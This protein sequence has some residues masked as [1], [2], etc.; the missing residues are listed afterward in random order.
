[1]EKSYTDTVAEEEKV[2]FIVNYLKPMFDKIK[3]YDLRKSRKLLNKKEYLLKLDINEEVF[4]SKELYRIGQYIKYCTKYSGFKTYL[5]INLS[6]VNR[7]QDKITYL[8]LDMMIFY[9]VNICKTSY[10]NLIYNIKA[11]IF[12][13]SALC[14]STFQRYNIKYPKEFITYK[15]YNELYLK[16]RL[17]EYHDET[18]VFYRYLYT[19]SDYSKLLISTIASEVQSTLQPYFEKSWINNVCKIIEEIIDNAIS[20]NNSMFILDLHYSTNLSSNKEKDDYEYKGI[21][22]GIINIGEQNLYTKLME[23]LKMR[24]YSE[25]DEVY[26]KIYAAYN[27]HKEKFCKHYN[28]ELFFMVT[29]FQ[30]DVT[31]RYKE[32]GNSGRGM[33]T[34]IRKLSEKMSYQNSY[35]LSGK[36]AILFK[37]DFLNVSD[38]G[39]IGFNKNN[40]Y[41][42]SIP[43]TSVISSSNLYCP[44]TIYNFNLIEKS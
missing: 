25:E 5:E 12:N 34:L 1:M 29:S 13:N 28:E 40:D 39:S 17:T 38:K 14:T 26:S 31:S 43:D 30:K 27:N 2:K 42:N 32:T 24:Y 9:F 41:I 4:T 22:L 10:C 16:K 19:E 44:G 20:H 21:S 7:F 23:N 37:K 3:Y 11:S 18:S 15:K 8:I 36:D 35:V 6:K 33:T